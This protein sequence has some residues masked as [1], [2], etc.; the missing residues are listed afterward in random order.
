MTVC[1]GLWEV[2][3]WAARNPTSTSASTSFNLPDLRN[4]QP[5]DMITNLPTYQPKPTT[6]MQP[7]HDQLTNQPARQQAINIIHQPVTTN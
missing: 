1:A 5:T 6:Q 7:T 2:D 4:Q 3:S